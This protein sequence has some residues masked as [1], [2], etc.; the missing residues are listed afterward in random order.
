MLETNTTILLEM[1]M[2]AMMKLCVKLT[3][4]EN[5][6]YV[7]FIK[8]GQL[9]LNKPNIVYSIQRNI[10]VEIYKAGVPE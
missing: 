8:G 5:E 9:I 4:T 7:S 10:Q 2:K 3:I 6:K 1:S